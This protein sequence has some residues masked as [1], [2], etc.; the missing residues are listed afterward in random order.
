MATGVVTVSA[1]ALSSGVAK[2]NPAARA[3]TAR[4][5]YFGAFAPEIYE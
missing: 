5:A 2:N 3:A 4:S 1:L